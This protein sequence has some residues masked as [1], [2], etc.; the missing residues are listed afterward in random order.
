MQI[1][2]Y[3]CPYTDCIRFET[4]T[5]NVTTYGFGT[6]K[7]CPSRICQLKREIIQCNLGVLWFWGEKCVMSGRKK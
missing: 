4:E 1:A 3:I 6:C 5:I 7:R 2:H